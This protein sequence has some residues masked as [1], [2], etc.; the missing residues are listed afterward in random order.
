MNDWIQTIGTDPSND[1]VLN[2]RF[3]R[4]PFHAQLRKLHGRLFIKDLGSE[5]GTWVN[6]DRIRSEGWFEISVFDTV[7]LGAVG[8]EG[9]R[10]ARLA[11]T[12]SMYW[13]IKGAL[14][15]SLETTRMTIRIGGKTL[16]DG[17]F[18]RIGKGRICAIIGRAGC[19]KSIFL[20]TLAGLRRASDGRIFLSDSRIRL[21][22][23]AGGE[24]NYVSFV[25]QADV[26]IGDLTVEA[27][28]E[29]RISLVYPGMAPRI[30]D[31]IVHSIA[32]SLGFQG[33]RLQKFLRTRIGSPE[34]RAAVLSG[35]ERRRASV[36]HEM[37]T[38]P[39]ALLLDEPTSG[40][41]SVDAMEVVQ[42]LKR[43]AQSNRIPIA[44]SIHQ[45]ANELFALFDDL[46]VM[47]FGGRMLYHGPSAGAAD[48]L[49]RWVWEG[50]EEGA[51]PREEGEKVD[52][53]DAQSAEF[54]LKVQEN[55]TVR[56]YLVGRFESATRD[57]SL[58]VYRP[59]SQDDR[60]P[61]ARQGGA[62][63]GD[64]L[65][66]L[67]WKA[68]RLLLVFW[69]LV[70]R[71]LD[72]LRADRVNLRFML[73]QGPM[74]AV[75]IWLAFSMGQDTLKQDDQFA[76][77]VYWGKILSD[78]GKDRTLKELLLE[79]G[80]RASKDL[81]KVGEGHARLEATVLFVLAFAI[82]WLSTVGAA[83]EIVQDYGVIAQE[84]RSGIGI[85]PV[86]F[87]R[88]FVLSAVSALQAAMLLG[89]VGLMLL[90]SS[91]PAWYVNSWLALILCGSLS[92]SVGMLVSVCSST[93]RLALTIVPLI[94]I[95]QVLFSGVLQT[96]PIATTP[97]MKYILSSQPLRLGWEGLLQVSHLWSDGIVV[98]EGQRMIN[99]RQG[100]FDLARNLVEAR[101]DGFRGLYFGGLDLGGQAFQLMV[102]EGLVFLAL[103]IGILRW[104]IRRGIR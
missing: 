95:P 60:K 48:R 40:L 29:S 77:T 33:D 46:L 20:E 63:G 10:P 27:S 25:P 38:N 91:N 1:V 45:P 42:F 11:F 6:Q 15:L 84:S 79:S 22:P 68:Q 37:V 66:Q 103:A 47:A 89:V 101:I 55:P 43:T 24:A 51:I 86:V 83:K 41:S 64:G 28:L 88:F 61:A 102:A 16:C 65:S 75:L 58:P 13:G 23:Y 53:L 39:M 78:D 4:S 73:L 35:G 71:S 72:T 14:G 52:N 62:G 56:D 12:P 81:G 97:L 50:V 93:Y 26:L 17:A 2:A 44:V 94:T 7:E 34:V 8:V 70:G 32:E 31:R 85:L 54:Y 90:K 19:G 74:L 49:R 96:V 57:E 9:V 30:R 76:R 36:G 80:E 69:V 98:L 67:L 5:G 18:A 59:L 100:A 92:T 99:S 21:D 3:G 82:L 87:S 104:R